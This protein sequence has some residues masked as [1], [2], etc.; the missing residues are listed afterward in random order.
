ML[1]GRKKMGHP[2]EIVRLAGGPGEIGHRFILN[3]DGIRRSQLIITWACFTW[4]ALWGTSSRSRLGG[5][6]A[7]QL[8]RVAQLTAAGKHRHQQEGQYPQPFHPAGLLSWQC[9]SVIK[10]WQ[11]TEIVRHNGA[12]ANQI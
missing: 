3:S 12:R 6:I 9:S 7:T 8:P 5:P 11:F 2:A 4:C 10:S 1:V